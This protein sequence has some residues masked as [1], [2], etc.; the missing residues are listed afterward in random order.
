MDDVVS[1][2][3]IMSLLR[4]G[5][6]KWNRWIDSQRIPIPNE[7]L[8]HNKQ[9]VELSHPPSSP[10]LS[11]MDQTE[12]IQCQLVQILSIRINE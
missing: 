8:G 5:S 11:E 6:M 7:N 9:T 1:D 10:V 12:V 3:N 2:N 4:F